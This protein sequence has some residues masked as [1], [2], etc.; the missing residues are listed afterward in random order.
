MANSYF[1]KYKFA[2]ILLTAEAELI[3]YNHIVFKDV[4]GQHMQYEEYDWPANIVEH[5]MM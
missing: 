3:Y 1:K 2:G 4:Q 5:T